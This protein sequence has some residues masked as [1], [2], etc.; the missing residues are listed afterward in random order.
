MFLIEMR[1][2]LRSKLLGGEGRDET[3]WF[4]LR[5]YFPN[6]SFSIYIPC[7]PLDLDG[8]LSSFMTDS[9]ENIFSLLQLFFY[10]AVVSLYLLSTSTISIP[11]TGDGMNNGQCP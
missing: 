9:I 6:L 11:G 2:R 1:C 8:L 10:R 7:F 5:R 3:A 4:F